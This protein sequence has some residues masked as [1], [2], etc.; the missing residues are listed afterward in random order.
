MFRAQS[1][2]SSIHR[3]LV[4]ALR[5]PQVTVAAWAGKVTGRESAGP[6]LL[7]ALEQKVT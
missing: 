4:D 3:L 6:L 5:R 1:Q 7:L 2:S